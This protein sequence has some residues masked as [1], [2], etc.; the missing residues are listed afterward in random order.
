MYTHY[1]E[2][3]GKVNK[4]KSLE[5]K[6]ILKEL[7]REVL[8]QSG[9][10]H[11]SL[12]DQLK[13]ELYDEVEIPYSNYNI[14]TAICHQ[15]EFDPANGTF[16]SM[17]PEL[18]KENSTHYKN[19]GELKKALNNQGRVLL[20]E[21]FLEADYLILKRLLESKHIFHGRLIT[22][23]NQ[24][25]IRGELIPNTR[26][27]KLLSELMEYYVRN[28]VEVR[29]INSPYLYKFFDVYLCH[30]ESM[31]TTSAAKKEDV[32]NAQSIIEIK[33]DLGEYERYRKDHMVPLWNV[34]F[35][36]MSSSLF[37]VPQE[38]SVY[39]R[40][41]ILLDPQEK[42]N[43]GYLIGLEKGF[44][45]YVSHYSDKI[46]V[47]SKD[48]TLKSWPVIRIHQGK[49]KL[50]IHFTYPIM[51]NRIKQEFIHRYAEFYG[52]NIRTEAELRRKL[53]SYEVSDA[54]TYLYCEIA[55]EIDREETYPLFDYGIHERKGKKFMVLHF[56]RN[57][58]E[59]IARD[60]MSFLVSEISSYFQE[61]HVVGKLE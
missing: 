40:S 39:Y 30:M 47:F 45:G 17:K 36:T 50:P 55:D 10:Y 20:G 34:E 6:T 16:Y 56:V 5:D 37:P 24:Y 60:I 1:D 42:G 8:M 22:R 12:M 57:C 27:I 46:S 61:Y 14:M 33:Y 38:N 19:M 13:K 52:R 51:T 2:I 28:H 44:D 49:E 4:V 21:V 43:D 18:K 3:C 53:L 35:L 41:D 48:S 26:Y 32:Q 25:R 59:F 23:E 15:N 31:I 9:E 54:V 7:I 11:R 58:D 29:T